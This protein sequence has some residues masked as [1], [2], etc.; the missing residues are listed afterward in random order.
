MTPVFVP[1]RVFRDNLRAAYPTVTA[2]TDSSVCIRNSWSCEL[3]PFGTLA[4]A[5]IL[6]KK[7]TPF[8]VNTKRIFKNFI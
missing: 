7:Y 4:P 6:P 5:F 1:V 8:P 2:G 3:H